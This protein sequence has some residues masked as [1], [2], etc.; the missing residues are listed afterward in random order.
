MFYPADADSSPELLNRCFGCWLCRAH[1]K[2]VGELR[3]AMGGFPR[4][5]NALECA[6]A[7][8][9]DTGER[10]AIT[11][12]RTHAPLGSA[13]GAND[14]IADKNSSRSIG[15]RTTCRSWSGRG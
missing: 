4:Q 2:V 12:G 6:R 3:C 10:D 9:L 1:T 7:V 8:A 5:L 15:R 14:R 11:P 13:G